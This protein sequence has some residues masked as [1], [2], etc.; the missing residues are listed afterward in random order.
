MKVGLI[1]F[2]LLGIISSSF[3]QSNLGNAATVCPG[4]TTNQD[5]LWVGTL[6][7]EQIP[8]FSQYRDQRLQA[9]VNFLNSDP[10]VANF[11]AMCIQELW[12][13]QRKQFLTQGVQQ[14]FPYSFAAPSFSSDCSFQCDG[15]NLDNFDSCFSDDC[16][17]NLGDIFSDNAWDCLGNTCSN[18]FDN[19]DTD[20]QI[21]VTA[22]DN[23]GLQNGVKSCRNL[24]SNVVT[25]A[26]TCTYLY[27]GN[28]D[29]V[30]LS[31]YPLIETNY[32]LYSTSPYVAATALHGKFVA[33]S[34]TVNLFC[35]HLLPANI[36]PANFQS[37]NRA[38]VQELISWVNNIT[39]PG[40]FVVIAGDFNTGPETQNTD[41]EWPTNFQ[42]F[43]ANGLESTFLAYANPPT[44]S[45]CGAGGNSLASNPTIGV[46]KGRDLLIDHVFIRNNS[47]CT[48]ATGL[49][50]TSNIVNVDSK[51]VPLSD[52]YGV[53]AAYCLNGTQTTSPLPSTIPTASPSSP[54]VVVGGQQGSSAWALAPVTM[55]VAGLAALL[56]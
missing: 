50:A 56:L 47:A 40:E 51:S 9:T 31:K 37:T 10:I 33:G 20:C 48:A 3:G 44:C 29:N 17:Q 23:S 21:C 42:I 36:Q 18:A 5:L 8:T 34:A 22:Q 11:D 13:T 14:T 15:N 30:L 35:T 32:L 24:T 1:T 55:M 43:P 27:G 16:F 6:N 25:T 4:C 7:T 28:S 46:E 45:Y 39:L 52:H 38:Q 49:F 41:G 12:A 2:L 19:L 53:F 54:V 26:G